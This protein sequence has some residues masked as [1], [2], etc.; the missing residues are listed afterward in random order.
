MTMTSATPAVLDRS[1]DVLAVDGLSVRLGGRDVLRDVGFRIGSGQFVGLIGSNGA[2][3]TTLL[4]VI[5]GLVA[6]TARSIS[7]TC[8]RRPRRGTGMPSRLPSSPS[9]TRSR[10]RTGMS[11]SSWIFCGT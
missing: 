4:K 3:K 1:A 9:P 2:G 5:L 6:P 8:W 10:A 7:S 11:G